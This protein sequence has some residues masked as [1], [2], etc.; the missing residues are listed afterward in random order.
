MGYAQEC[1]YGIMQEYVHGVNA[2]ARSWYKCR[3]PL[4]G[5]VQKC[6]YGINAGV[7]SWYKC[8]SP[9]MGYAQ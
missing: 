9:L 2:G 8:R 3:I 6:N 5:Y 4:M 7:R 1:N